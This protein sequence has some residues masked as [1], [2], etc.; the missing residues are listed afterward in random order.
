MKWDIYYN[1]CEEYY[2]KYR[3]ILMPGNY[4]VIYE[5]EE[6][7]LTEWLNDQKIE[8][9]RGKLS[10][11]KIERLDKIGMNFKIGNYSL[12]FDRWYKY[13]ILC[14]Q[15]KDENGNIMVPYNYKV[16]MSENKTAFLWQWL[17]SQKK[18]YLLGKLSYIQFKLLDD[19][20]MDWTSDYYDEAEDSFDRNFELASKYYDKYGNLLFDKPFDAFDKY[21]NKIDL[22]KWICKLRR[23][24]K[25][26][27]LSEERINKLN[28]S[29]P[30]WNE[31]IRKNTWYTY[32][33]ALED[34]KEEYCDL[35]IPEGYK[36][37]DE[38]ENEY[39]L[40][41]WFEVQ[42]NILPFSK[43]RKEKYKMLDKLGVS[44]NKGI[45]ITILEK[46]INDEFN[47]YLKDMLDD[48][49]ID[50]L[51][52]SGAFCYKDNDIVKSTSKSYMDKIKQRVNT[53][54]K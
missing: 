18:K 4:I 15:F 32:F 40:Y 33:S 54:K 19:I 3:S 1:L 9:K 24:E 27:K 13:Y 28:N 43:K 17:K 47:K 36:F 49:E 41:G 53:H 25:I 51:I 23:Q 31:S 5:N 45:D 30:G 10:K 38:D 2:K 14:K 11:E 16:E 8:F 21:G 37:I 29:I 6:Y 20:G 12:L 7:N 48:D 44:W 26:K 39:D 42:K 22:K 46:Y 50:K 34:Y 35:F 52:F